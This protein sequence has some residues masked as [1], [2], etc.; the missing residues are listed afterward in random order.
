MDLLFVIFKYT[1]VITI[2]TKNIANKDALEL[3]LNR[4]PLEQQAVMETT[5]PNRS[6]LVNF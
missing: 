2:K 6:P 1:Q 4:R 5:I 3:Y